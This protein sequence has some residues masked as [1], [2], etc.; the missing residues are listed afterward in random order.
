MGLKWPPRTPQMHCYNDT[1]NATGQITLTTSW[2]SAGQ[3]TYYAE[4]AG[5][6]ATK[7]RREVSSG[8][9]FINQDTRARILFAHE[10]RGRC[11][12]QQ[13]QPV[14][15]RRAG[16]ERWHPGV[17]MKYQ[18]SATCA[19]DGDQV[20]LSDGDGELATVNGSARSF[21]LFVAPCALFL[22]SISRP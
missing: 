10:A 15:A 20:R 14:F 18:G 22:F 12:E 11:E 17:S 9:L 4:F 2:A 1:T 13:Y 7:T 21:S 6:T 8:S 5:D 3:R 16:A 19:L